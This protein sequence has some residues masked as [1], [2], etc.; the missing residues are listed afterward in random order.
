MIKS[1]LAATCILLPSLVSADDLVAGPAS[2]NQWAGCYAGVGGSYASND[3][4]TFAFNTYDGGSHSAT[5]GMLQARGGCDTQTGSIVLGVLGTID[6]GK[7][8]GVN[9]FF[10]VGPGFPEY[11][12][13]EVSWIGALKARAGVTLGNNV[14]VYGSAGVAWEHVSYSDFDEVPVLSFEGRGD[15]V[16][17]GYQLGVGAEIQVND[18]GRLFVEYTYSDFGSAD[19]IVTDTNPATVTEGPWSNNYTITTQMVTVGYTLRF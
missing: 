4:S 7:L 19:V 3:T 11:L 9:A 12:T 14:L 2:S 10:P 1:C 18:R 15:E 13:T 8:Q 5:G 6:G 17:Q 16:R